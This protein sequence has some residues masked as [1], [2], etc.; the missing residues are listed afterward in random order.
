MIQLSSVGLGALGWFQVVLSAGLGNYLVGMAAF[1]ASRSRNNI[2][3]VFGVF[4]PVLMFVALGVQHSPANMGFFMLGLTYSGIYHIDTGVGWGVAFGWNIVPASIGNI[5][6]GILLVL[7]LF[8]F[9]ITRRKPEC[10]P[11]SRSQL[12]NEFDGTKIVLSGAIN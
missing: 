4:F 9:G 10:N 11:N 12:E 2:S 8:S 3:T 6:G 7:L 1:L 5:V